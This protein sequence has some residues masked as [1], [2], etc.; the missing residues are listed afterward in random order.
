MLAMILQPG[1]EMGLGVS[2]LIFPILIAFVLFAMIV[3]LIA[4][5]KDRL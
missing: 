4:R 1:T 5:P 3:W 2:A